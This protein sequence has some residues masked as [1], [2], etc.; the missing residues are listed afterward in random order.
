MFKKML[1]ATDLS[2]ASESF[3][4]TLDGLKSLGTREAVLL[5]CLNI[6]DVGGLSHTLME[7]VKPSIERQKNMLEDLGFAATAEIAA[8]IPHIEIHRQAGKHDCSLVVVG[9]KGGSMASEILMGG[10]AGTVIHN[11]TR[12]TLVLH[13]QLKEESGEVTCEPAACE[14]LEHVLFPTDFSDNAEHA[15]GYVRGIARAGAKRITLFHVQDKG[16]IDRHLKHKLEEFNK[17][18][19]GRLNRLKDELGK[20]GAGDVRIEIPYGVP[21]KEILEFAAQEQ[22]SFIV[23][24]S[25]GRGFLEE[26]FL[27]SVSHAVAWKADMPVLLVPAKQ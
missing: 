26:V 12:P 2:E 7:I 9:S 21:K 3:L 22:A 23:I 4:C 13:P 8:G 15:F 19:T 11:A 10:V 1:V 18:D 5:H 17:I 25:Q 6:R 20:D 14:P 24:G 16:R 27:G